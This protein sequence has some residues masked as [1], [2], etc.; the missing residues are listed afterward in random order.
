[1]P[2]T[3][4]ESSEP[5]N[6]QLVELLVSKGGKR[7]WRRP[8]QPKKAPAPKAEFERDGKQFRTFEFD[9][10]PAGHESG[11]KGKEFDT[12]PAGQ[13]FDTGPAGQEFDTGPAG[14]EFDTGPAGQE[15][16]TGPAGQELDTG[17]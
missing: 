11:S 8:E 14:Q 17:S 10:G 6:A 15:F 3:L 16:D 5:K 1:M 2:L 9:V 12:G 4:A 7:T 13:E